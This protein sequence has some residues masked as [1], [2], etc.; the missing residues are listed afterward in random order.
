MFE[1]DSVMTC[2]QKIRMSSNK[3]ESRLAPFAV[4][5]LINLGKWESIDNQICNLD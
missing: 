2:I 5:A 3:F 4:E 1:W